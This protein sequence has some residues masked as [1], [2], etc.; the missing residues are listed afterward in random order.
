MTTRF[1]TEVFVGIHRNDPFSTY[2][3]FSKKLNISYPLI[4]TCIKEMFSGKHSG[5]PLPPFLCERG[6]GFLNSTKSGGIEIFQNQGGKKGGERGIFEI[7]IGGKISGDETSNR[8]QNFSK[9][10]KFSF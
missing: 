8:K 4:R 6:T 3:K 1:L 2:A 10:S 7:F 9:V 5:S